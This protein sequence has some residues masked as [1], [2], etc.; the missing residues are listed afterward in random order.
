[1][2][3]AVAAQERQHQLSQHRTL[4][5]QQ[6][7]QEWENEDIEH[8][9]SAAQ[10]SHDAQAIKNLSRNRRDAAHREAHRL[11]SWFP[12]PSVLRPVTTA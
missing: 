9:L 2:A 6:T 5:D 8:R 7:N 4:Q 12:Q 3:P 1:M 11:F 10:E